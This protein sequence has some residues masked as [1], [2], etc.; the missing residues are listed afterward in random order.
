MA[1]ML[2]VDIGGTNTDLIFVDTEQRV[3]RTAKVP[4]TA[5]NQAK[6][7]MNGIEALEMVPSEI[8]LIIHGTTV[9]TNAVIERKGARC[10][11]LTT[12]GFRDALELRRRD[13]P[14]TYGLDDSFYPLI[15]RELRLEISERVQANG[16]VL[17]PLDDNEVRE[18][19]RKL[20]ALGCEAVV[21]CFLHSYA[22][23]EHEKRA[24][25]VLQEIWPNSYITLSTEV[26]PTLREFER[27]STTV[28]NGYVQ[29]LI[30]RYFDR[31][32]DNLK[33]S[34]YNK[35]LLVVQSNGGVMASKVAARFAANTVLS[36]PAAGVTAATEIARDLKNPN[37]VSA[38]MGG[39]SLDV[40]IIKDY[41]A[42]VNQQTQLEFGIPLGLPMLDI[43][44]IGAGGGSLAYIDRAGLL[45]IGPES[46]GSDPGP[47]CYGRGGA[48]PTITDACLVLGLLDSNGIFGKSKG[49]KMDKALAFEAITTQIAKPLS[50]TTEAAAEAIVTV[51]GTK[52]AGHIRRKLLEKGC[53]PREFSIIAFGGGGPLHANRMLREAELASVIVPYYPGLTSAFG[54]ILGQL[55]HDFV[56]TV[57]FRL[58]DIDV[59]TLVRLFKEQEDEGRSLL[60]NEGADEQDVSV[61]FSA[62][63]KYAG[64]SH[65]IPVRLPT[66]GLDRAS[67]TKAFEE[68]YLSYY[69]N[70][71][72]NNEIVLADIRTSVVSRRRGP[73]LSDLV[74]LPVTKPEKLQTLR[75]YF[76]KGEI[77]APVYDRHSLPAGYQ[78]EG[79]AILV[80]ADT[81]VFVEPGYRASV[82][83]TGNVIIEAK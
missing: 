62:E 28:V 52:M 36:G 63:M 7:L 43:T 53:D 79:P 37:V 25:A 6:G 40:C 22:H 39:T 13:R 24:K 32:N 38:D 35:D 66:S 31:L 69:S 70:L 51:A 55:R 12:R 46:A 30:D 82:H 44:T 29:P 19:G 60:K 17:S 50:L 8:D 54:C 21:I 77:E 9:A 11:L 74:R 59:A 33:E 23:P 58:S 16:T 72:E 68:A 65:L 20:L 71:I 41:Q 61:I 5:D 75:M 10:G 76:G 57:N 49:P 27:T 73:S 14:K 64:Q 78:L 18:A 26:L 42:G 81:T 15:P 34:G 48:V 2:G 83:P 3:V 56:R 45:Q 47:V 67:I 1:R 4:T 80:Q